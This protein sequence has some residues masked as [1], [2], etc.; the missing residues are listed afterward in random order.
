MA[1]SASYVYN[2]N[3]KVWESQDTNTFVS[4][5]LTMAQDSHKLLTGSSLVGAALYQELSTNDYTNM[6]TA[7]SFEIRPKFYAFGAPARQKQIRE[8][9]PRFMAETS[10]YSV[11]CQYAADLR[12]AAQ[13]IT[14]GSVALQGS[15]ST[16][17]SGITWGDFTYDGNTFVQPHLNIPGDYYYIQPRYSHTATRQPVEFFGHY[18]LVQIRRLH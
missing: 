17:G 12:D 10:S 11:D 4:R 14:G 16:W 18:L 9:R 5:A 13:T 3:L 7:L 2:I 1:N 15:A 6:G 8:W